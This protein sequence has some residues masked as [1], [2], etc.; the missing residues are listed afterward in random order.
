MPKKN[1]TATEFVLNTLRQWPD[2][3]L[4]IS[5]FYELAGGRFK[6][7]NLSNSLTRLLAKGEVVRNIDDNRSAWWAISR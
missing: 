3:E 7:E 1:G 6:K 4:R 2:N 5:D